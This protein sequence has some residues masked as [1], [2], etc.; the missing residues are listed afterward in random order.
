MASVLG[1]V[2]SGTNPAGDTDMLRVLEQE[3]A[4]RRAQDLFVSRFKEHSDARIPVRIGWRPDYIDAAVNYSSQLDA[5]MYTQIEPG[6]RCWNAF[7]LA[8][9]SEG[10]NVSIVCEVNPPLS[11]INRGIAGVF[12]SDGSGQMCVGHR[13]L[14]GGGRPGV[15]KALFEQH[16][17]GE[18]VVAQDGSR[19]TPIALVCDLSSPRCGNQIGAFVREVDRIKLLPHLADTR[20]TV[21]SVP[22]FRQEFAGT[23]EYAVAKH[24]SASCNHGIVV[25]AL[26]AELRRRGFQT[27]SDARD[28]YTFSDTGRVSMIFEIKTDMSPNSLQTGIGQLVLYSAGLEPQPT[29]VL[30]IPGSLEKPLQDRLLQVGISTLHYR[31]T[32]ES[33]VFPEPDSTMS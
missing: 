6:S 9:P 11:G 25:N 8:R 21:P 28:L 31:L 22:Q 4:I 12:L 32:R 33:A 14:I 1:I 7:G 30:V 23:K 15:G 29:L 5:W 26:E 13:G 16:Y 10:Q 19:E 2:W 3:A 18:W 24:V 17:R 27:A 20:P